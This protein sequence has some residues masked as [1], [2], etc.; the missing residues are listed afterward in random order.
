MLYY[1]RETYR[2]RAYRGRNIDCYYSNCHY[3]GDFGLATAVYRN[4]HAIRRAYKRLVRRKL[5]YNCYFCATPRRKFALQC[6]TTPPELTGYTYAL[7]PAAKMANAP[8]TGTFTAKVTLLMRSLA[9]FPILTPPP[10]TQRLWRRRIC[11][12][13]AVL[14]KR[15]N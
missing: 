15:R 9:K 7:A 2:A 14:S 8:A 4:E 1:K 3:C 6:T 10:I 12:T 11:R 13:R 5:H